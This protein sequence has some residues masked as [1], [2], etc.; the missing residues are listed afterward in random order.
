MHPVK[1]LSFYAISVLAVFVA[2]M[3]HNEGILSSAATL[4]GDL[5]TAVRESGNGL[6]NLRI[7]GDTVVD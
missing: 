2:L 3:H 4:C 5:E 6:E 7:Y 1:I